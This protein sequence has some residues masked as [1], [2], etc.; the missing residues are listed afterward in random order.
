MR[1]L[2]VCLSLFFCLSASAGTTSAQALHDLHLVLAFDA[3]ASVNDAEFDLQR[4]GTAD[5]LRSDR[6]AG[7]IADRRPW[8]GAPDELQR[9]RVLLECLDS[10]EARSPFEVVPELEEARQTVQRIEKLAKELRRWK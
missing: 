2:A 10:P 7:A 8:P 5:A 1:L 9:Y 4:R 6:V 3:S